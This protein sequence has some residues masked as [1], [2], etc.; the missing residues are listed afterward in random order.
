MSSL[1]QQIG[2]IE[3]RLLDN[4]LLIKRYKDEMEAC[5]QL[6]LDQEVLIDQLG[7]E[8]QLEQELDQL[9]ATASAY[10]DEMA[11][12][13]KKLSQCETDIGDCRQK[14]SKLMDELE[15]NER[16]ARDIVFDKEEKE[17]ELSEQLRTALRDKNCDLESQVLIRFPI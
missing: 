8:S 11:S 1:E 4:E 10:E 3:K 16:V 2:S 15:E 9:V 14:I 13:K 7:D 17:R 5:H 12:L 6:W